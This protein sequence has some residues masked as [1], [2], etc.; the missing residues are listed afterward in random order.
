MKVANGKDHA[1]ESLEIERTEICVS[2][3]INEPIRC[4]PI[5]ERD[6]AIITLESFEFCFLKRMLVTVFYEGLTM[7]GAIS[8][9]V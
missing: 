1:F 8:M 4:I 5:K 9:H 7:E 3:V 2:C 6:I